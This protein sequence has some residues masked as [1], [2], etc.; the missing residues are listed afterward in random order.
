VAGRHDDD[1]I[2]GHVFFQSE[3]GRH[4]ITETESIHL[5]VLR[6]SC[7]AE[8]RPPIVGAAQFHWPLIESEV[9]GGGADIQR[10]AGKN[11]LYEPA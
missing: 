10:A 9:A 3:H 11:V 8:V 6:S 2:F 7:R 4:T 1:A 5:V